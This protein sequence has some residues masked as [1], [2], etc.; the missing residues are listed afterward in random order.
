MHIMYRHSSRHHT[1][2]RNRVVAGPERPEDEQLF[3]DKGWCKGSSLCLFESH[4]S[5][6]INGKDG[7][8]E[9]RRRGAGAHR[10]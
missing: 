4:D 3:H 6:L 10:P 1:S 9:L 2:I 5:A 7:Q 8:P